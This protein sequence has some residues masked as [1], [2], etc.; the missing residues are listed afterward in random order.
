VR[1]SA[2]K[3]VVSALGCKTFDGAKENE[4]IVNC[5]AYT[6]E[7]MVYLLKVDAVLSQDGE[8]HLKNIYRNF[9]NTGKEQFITG[10]VVSN[11]FLVCSSDNL[12]S[13]KSRERTSVLVFRIYNTTT[14]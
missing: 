2:L 13:E 9:Y 7:N 4:K 14:W 3:G 8:L 10:C 6:N 12:S 11:E 1:G 5:W